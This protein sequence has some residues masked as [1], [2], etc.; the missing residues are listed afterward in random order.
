MIHIRRIINRVKCPKCGEYTKIRLF[1]SNMVNTIIAVL[2]IV[3]CITL[4]PIIG[5]IT[6]PILLLSSALCCKLLLSISGL[7]FNSKLLKSSK[8]TQC[9]K[10]GGLITFTKEENKE[11]KKEI[12]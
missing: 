7:L 12:E 9:E 2:M 11:V 3:G 4:I 6:V 8:L 1:K 5:W 10:C